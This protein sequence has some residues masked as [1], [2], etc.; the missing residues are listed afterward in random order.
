M[1]THTH[2]QPYMQTNTQNHEHRRTEAHTDAPT[3]TH[4][5]IK[6]HTCSNST[7]TQKCTQRQKHTRRQMLADTHTHSHMHKPHTHMHIYAT[8]PATEWDDDTMPSRRTRPF[9]SAQAT[10]LSVRLLGCP[11]DGGFLQ[12][13]CVLRLA[14]MFKFLYN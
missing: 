4:T 14:R 1:R 8:P 2:R 13:T 3:D 11:V 10:I 5:H 12:G 6:K 9:F 7:Y